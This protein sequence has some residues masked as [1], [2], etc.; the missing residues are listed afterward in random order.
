MEQTDLR[1]HPHASTRGLCGSYEIAFIAGDRAPSSPEG[2]KILTRADPALDRPMI[3]FQNIVE[4][5]HRSMST[6]LLQSALGFE[7]YDGWR[8]SGL[9]VGVDHPRGGMVRT[10]QGFGQK[11][12]GGHGVALGRKK[13]VEGR[14][15]GIHRTIQVAPLALDP[16]VGLGHPPTVVGRSE[17]QSQLALNFW[18]VTLNPPPDGDV[19]DQ[20]STLSK[21]FLDVTVRQ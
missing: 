2:A 14:P 11:A 10:S 8:V 1:T 21:E 3:L 17:P 20:K 16:D 9:L 5:L 19:V 15:S 7:L 18:G 4:I 12:L 6:V 13:E